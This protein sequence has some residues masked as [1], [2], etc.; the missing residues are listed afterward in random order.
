MIIGIQSVTIQSDFFWLDSDW[1]MITNPNLMR[2]VYDDEEE[3]SIR[4]T[5][6]VGWIC[7]HIHTNTCIYECMY[8][9]ELSRQKTITICSRKKEEWPYS[10]FFRQSSHMI[11][12]S[13]QFQLYK[14]EALYRL[15][16]FNSHVFHFLLTIWQWSPRYT[17]NVEKEIISNQIWFNISRIFF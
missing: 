7:V 10:N 5:I 4:G 1:A 14:E 8:L 15:N 13:S 3:D 12:T 11:T 6:W 17:N 2:Q 9:S 16:D